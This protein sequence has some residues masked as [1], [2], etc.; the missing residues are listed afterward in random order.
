MDCRI[1][2]TA[3]TRTVACSRTED[4]DRFERRRWRR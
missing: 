2:R 3:C 4:V 1:A